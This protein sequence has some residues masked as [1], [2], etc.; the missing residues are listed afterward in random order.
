ML[1]AGLPDHGSAASSCCLVLAK[2]HLV[3]EP[4]SV[5]R[6]LLPHLPYSSEMIISYMSFLFMARLPWRNG[7]ATGLPPP[8]PRPFPYPCV[9]LAL[10]LSWVYVVVVLCV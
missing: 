3:Q 6:F 1:H 4:R 8:P 2:C 7:R 5:P 10:D 9:C